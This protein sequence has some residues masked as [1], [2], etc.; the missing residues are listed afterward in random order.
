MYY[1]KDKRKVQT[2]ID[3][4]TCPHFNRKSK[5]CNGIGKTC[6]EYDIKTKTAIDPI[7]R[8]PIKL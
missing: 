2:N 1:N 6:F 5:K 8:L 4:I 3:C 7:S